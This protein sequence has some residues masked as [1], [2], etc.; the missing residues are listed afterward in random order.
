MMG[1]DKLKGRD[2]ILVVVASNEESED[3]PV[4]WENCHVKI[5]IL[6]VEGSK[7]VVIQS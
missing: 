2:H 5:S 1:A 7:Q 3:L 4:A 6:V